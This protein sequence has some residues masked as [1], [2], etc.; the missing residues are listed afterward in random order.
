MEIFK[1]QLEQSHLSTEELE[2]DELEIIRLRQ[3]KMFPDELA[4]LKRGESMKKSSYIHGLCPVLDDVLRVGGRLS[5]A[6]MPQ[7]F[8]H[9][10]QEFSHLGYPPET[11]TPG[12]RTCWS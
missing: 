2:T 10:G 1:G 8:S 9:F 11:H 6:S 4:I 5:R 3:E 7:T 12:R